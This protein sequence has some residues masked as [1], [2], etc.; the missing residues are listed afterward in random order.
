MAEL[1]AAVPKVR[2]P[3]VSGFMYASKQRDLESAIKNQ[4]SSNNSP[5]R[6]RA[7]LLPQGPFEHT[8]NISGALYSQ[9]E[10]PRKCIL[11]GESHARSRLRW[12]LVSQG[13]FRTPLGDVPI[14]VEM[15]KRLSELT[16]HFKEDP[17]MQRG[18]HAIEV[19]LPYLQTLGPSD[20][21][22]VPIIVNSNRIQEWED[23]ASAIKQ[24]ID[25]SDEP[26]LFI[27]STN[28][29]QFAQQITIQNQNSMVLEYI[30][31]TQFEDFCQYLQVEDISLG[32]LAVLGTFM[33]FNRCLGVSNIEVIAQG[34]SADFGGDPHSA[35]G[36]AS[37]RVE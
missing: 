24:V 21:T 32:G 1:T 29:A 4:C 31:H 12:S 30:K 19:Q 22:I 13:E 26:V 7:V 2:L 20:L 23:V 34:T 18:E 11:L 8:S 5:S 25:E 16:P 10:V 15:T 33:Q 17:F 36:Y 27:C 37:V 28:L 3:A 14:D 35:T 6:A 9:L